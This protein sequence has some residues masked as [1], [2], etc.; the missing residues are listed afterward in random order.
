MSAYQLV[1]MPSSPRKRT[2][3]KGEVSPQASTASPP[4]H[5]DKHTAHLSVDILHQRHDYIEENISCTYEWTINQQCRTHDG[6]LEENTCQEY[7]D[8]IC[9]DWMYVWHYIT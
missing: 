4:L 8:I 1:I 7:L 6:F 9:F 2:H 3:D 5:C